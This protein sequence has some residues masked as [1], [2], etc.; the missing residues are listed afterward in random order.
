MTRRR[1]LGL[2]ALVAALLVATGAVVTT[3]LVANRP[4]APVAGPT[5]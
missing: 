1:L 4:A 5:T 2:A 3:R